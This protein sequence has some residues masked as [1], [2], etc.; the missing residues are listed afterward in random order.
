MGCS[1]RLWQG[2]CPAERA[3]RR[4][5]IV[6]C[7]PLQPPI[8]PGLVGFLPKAV[9]HR[10]GQ[11]EDRLLLER[12]PRL[13]GRAQGRRCSRRLDAAPHGARRS[14]SRHVRVHIPS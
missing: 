8:V 12:P 10:L 14:G 4:F 11:L 7:D 3:R 5:V 2:P 13:P 1:R 6:P 9:A